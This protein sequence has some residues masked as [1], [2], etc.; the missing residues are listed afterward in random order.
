MYA[1][2]PPSKCWGHTCV[3]AFPLAAPQ[4][5]DSQARFGNVVRSSSLR[6]MMDGMNIGILVDRQREVKRKDVFALSPKH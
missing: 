3:Y 1:C 5:P 4:L 6:W 2:V